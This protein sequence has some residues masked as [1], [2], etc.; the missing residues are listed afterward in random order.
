MRKLCGVKV[1]SHGFAR[2]KEQ[3]FLFLKTC[4]DDTP[5]LAYHVR[6]MS[7]LSEICVMI[8]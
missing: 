8:L 4:F 3:G 6:K 5:S 1:E 2:S 7:F